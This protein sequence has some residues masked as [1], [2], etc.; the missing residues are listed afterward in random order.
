ML[1]RVTNLCSALIGCN[2]WK[3]L[4]SVTLDVAI[5]NHVWA[6]LSWD[7]IKHGYSLFP[8]YHDEER[9]ARF[10]LFNMS[11]SDTTDLYEYCGDQL[12]GTSIAFLLLNII[13]VTLRFVARRSTGQSLALDDCLIVGALVANL[14]LDPLC[15]GLLLPSI[16]TKSPC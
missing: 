2:V 5:L 14:A 12:V 9:F 8:F 11:S 4:N 10:R 13:F 16:L 6:R 15:L 1:I 3:W 7:I